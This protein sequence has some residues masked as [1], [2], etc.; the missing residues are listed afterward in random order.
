MTCSTFKKR[1]SLFEMMHFAQGMYV[2]SFKNFCSQVIGRT[3]AEVVVN[4]LVVKSIYSVTHWPTR[5]RRDILV[6]CVA[7]HSV[8]RITCISIAKFMASPVL[9]SA[10]YVVQILSKLLF[11]FRFLFR[12]T[13]KSRYFLEQTNHSLCNITFLCIKRIIAPTTSRIYHFNA[14]YVKRDF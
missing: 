13:N 14:T 10:T 6:T 11:L 2:K 12:L 3:C 4:L 7:R 8:A 9:T 5:A 1:I